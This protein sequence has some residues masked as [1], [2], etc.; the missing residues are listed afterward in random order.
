[1][2]S[3]SKKTGGIIGEAKYRAAMLCDGE[4]LMELDHDDYLLPDAVELMVKAFTEYPDAGYVYSDCVECDMELNSMCYGDDF[5]FSYGSYYKQ[6]YNDKELDVCACVPVNP[7]TIRHIV[8]VPNHF[9]SWRRS[10]YHALGGHNRKL[11]IADDYEITVRAFL[12]T[13][14]VR[15][16]KCCY[17]QF[18]DGN[19]TQNS[20]GGRTRKDIQRRVRSIADKYNEDIKNRFEEVGMT[21][22]AYD[23]DPSSPLMAPSQFDSGDFAYTLKI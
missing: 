3:F 5:A 21:D 14:F 16:P 6:T 22:W 19:N 11:T 8:G 18:Y 13:R 12:M 2:Y 23:Y 7:K 17:L 20:D 9:R 1:V 15:I 10:T 4:Y